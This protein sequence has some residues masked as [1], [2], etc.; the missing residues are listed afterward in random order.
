M[1]KMRYDLKTAKNKLE[2]QINSDELIFLNKFGELIN[3]KPED[4]VEQLI[5]EEI[6]RMQ[7]ELKVIL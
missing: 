6:D 3:R 5:H 1:R 4:I 2:I 7:S